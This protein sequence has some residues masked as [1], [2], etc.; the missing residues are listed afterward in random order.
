MKLKRGGVPPESAALKAIAGND[1]YFRSEEKDDILA[2]IS[3]H[4]SR[5]IDNWHFR[6][7]EYMLCFDKHAFE[8][9]NVLAQC[10][11]ERYGNNP[12]YASMAKIVLLKHV[13]LNDAAANLSGE[14]TWKMVEDIKNG[15]E[16]FLQTKYHW[17]N[18]SC[19]MSDGPFRTKQ[20]TL[21]TDYNI[22]YGSSQREAKLNDIATRTGCR[23]RVT[24]ERF[25]HQLFSITGPKKA[26]PLAT[27]L[28]KDSLLGGA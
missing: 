10:C 3:E 20:I 7:Y 11:K 2:R 9:L 14:E 25:D 22:K 4:R 17:G 5:G 26:L 27:S 1:S 16:G 15:I 6:K 24:D 23:I 8:A 19:S 12:S 21:P 18:L 28:L 13:R